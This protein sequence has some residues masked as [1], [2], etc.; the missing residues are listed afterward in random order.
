MLIAELLAE[1]AEGSNMQRTGEI[2]R[3]LIE[4]AKE[5]VKKSHLS[6]EMECYLPHLMTRDEILEHFRDSQLDFWQYSLD[7]ETS[8]L[9]ARDS[10]HSLHNY[11]EDQQ[12]LILTKLSCENLF[13]HIMG[14]S[15]LGINTKLSKIASRLALRRT[16]EFA[17]HLSN[18]FPE[19]DLS[20]IE[21]AL[22]VFG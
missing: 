20:N 19:V 8:Q 1:L 2:C 5:E 3:S 11:N 13:S 21:R 17:K 14:N 15:D 22:Q 16:D 9:L 18:F 4:H 12:Y 7:S 10:L 6:A